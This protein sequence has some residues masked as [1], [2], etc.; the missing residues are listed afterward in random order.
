MKTM[1]ELKTQLTSH[2]APLDLLYMWVKQGVV[3]K[4][5]FIQ[6]VALLPIGDENDD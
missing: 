5:Q 1:L 4:N 3:S 6:L 2:P